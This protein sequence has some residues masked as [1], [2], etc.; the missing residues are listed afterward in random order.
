MLINTDASAIAEIADKLIDSRQALPYGKGWLTSQ[1]DEN[2]QPKLIIQEG[3]LSGMPGITLL[4]MEIYEYTRV[5]KY[6]QAIIEGIEFLDHY[7]KLNRTTNYSLYTGRM[8]TAWTFTKMWQLTGNGTYL[9][10]ALQIARESIHE[11]LDA[12]TTDDSFENGRSGVLFFLLWLHQESEYEEVLLLIN[13]YIKKI[14]S[15]V[16][17]RVTGIGWKQPNE[18]IHHTPGSGTGNAAISY[19]FD[20]L[21]KYFKNDSFHYIAQN[22]FRTESGITVSEFFTFQLL[23]PDGIPL[24]WTPSITE[25][26]IPTSTPISYPL[27]HISYAEIRKI[28]LSKTFNRTIYLLEHFKPEALQVFFNEQPADITIDHIGFMSLAE[29][30]ISQLSG[31]RQILLDEI[32]N[33]ERLKWHIGVEHNNNAL[34]NEHILAT[35]KRSAYILN[36]DEDAF[37]A[38]ALRLCPQTFIFTTTFYPHMNLHQGLN[39]KNI[40]KEKTAIV[41]K[42]VSHNTRVRE[43]RITELYELEY[44]NEG[45]IKEL[46][47]KETSGTLLSFFKEG[48]TI[49]AVLN[50]ILADDQNATSQ[51]GKINEIINEIRY[52]ISEQ[53]LLPVN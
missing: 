23:K 39:E 18:H 14:L 10:C 36:A 8:G 46:I 32:F 50:T 9:E 52:Y 38:T 7:I 27:L 13:L 35:R 2:K 24:F 37:F 33:L 31:D 47:V 51:T 4:L 30:I 42:P 53:I 6:F 5:E 1:Y 15:G 48:N 21:G 3:L 49:S 19:V 43:K 26:V 25:A 40:K 17:Y 41:L 45:F 16:Q 11:F 29:S 22:A 34:N 12:D 20:R 44:Q 28:V